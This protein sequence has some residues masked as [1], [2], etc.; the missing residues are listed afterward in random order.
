MPAHPEPPTSD[1]A[2]SAMLGAWLAF[3]VDLFDIY[4]PIVVLAPAMPYFIPADL[5][6]GQVAI[7]SGA[8]FA[9]TLVARPL[10]AFIFGRIADTLGRKRTTLIAVAGAGATTL[11]IVAL[12]GYQQ[13]GGAAVI[14]L[15]ALRFVAGVLLGGEYTAANPLAME[16]APKHRR[17]LYSGII[18]TGFPLAYAVV[19]LITMVLL[20][21]LPAEGVGSAYVQWGWRIPF[22]VGGVLSLVLVLYYRHAVGESRVFDQAPREP[23]PIRTLFTGSNL[24]SLLQVFVL[25]NGFWLSLQPIAA[26]LPPLLAT[27]VPSLAGPGITGAL[28]IA[29]LVLAP[30]NIASALISQRV[31]RRRFLIGAG[32]LMA[33]AS[34]VIYY[35]LV[36]AT[37][38][39]FVPLALL[40][41]AATV[42]V[43]GPWGVLPAYINERFRTGI[44][45]S[46]YGISYST[47]VVLPSFYAFYQVAL[48]HLMP[49]ELTGIV[50]L[51][52]GALLVVAGGAFGPETRDV[53]FTVVTVTPT[54]ARSTG[55]PSRTP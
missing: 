53:D 32:L 31:G 11:L 49:L 1:Q 7:A 40:V 41:T 50:I 28:V 35:L 39:H 14:A 3:F 37:P 38:T 33:I 46:G 19:S 12:P 2:R 29:Y 51:I 27:R 15:V 21:A 55:R 8:I 45:A 13:W 22:A 5:D 30:A 24:R 20:A 17:G 36:R 47:A 34:P 6:P 9:A 54:S 43:I 10:G 4:L 16:A 48:S 44:R 25:M 42:V 18:N 26:V 52:A 23:T